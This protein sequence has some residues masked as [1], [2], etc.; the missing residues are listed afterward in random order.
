MTI[1]LPQPRFEWFPDLNLPNKILEADGLQGAQCLSLAG[2]SVELDSTALARGE[3][4][5][6]CLS[7]AIHLLDRCFRPTTNWVCASVVRQDNR[8]G[9]HLGLWRGLGGRW[10]NFAGTEIHRENRKSISP[11]QLQFFGVAPILKESEFNVAGAITPGSRSFLVATPSGVTPDLQGLVGSGW[12]RGPADH[13]ELRALAVVIAAQG[14]VLFGPF[15]EFDDQVC[16]IDCL[17]SV[18]SFLDIYACWRAGEQ[19]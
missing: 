14:G 10:A 6:C 15:G 8:I 13:D 11:D 1:E 2:V 16:G 4:I 17:M 5:E 12:S 19:G 18:S 3:T 7:S 9:K